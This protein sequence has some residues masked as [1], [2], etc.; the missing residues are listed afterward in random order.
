MYLSHQ[1]TWLHHCAALLYS[2]SECQVLRQGTQ[3]YSPAKMQFPVLCRP[4]SKRNMTA[5]TR[6]CQAQH[7]SQCLPLSIAEISLKTMVNSPLLMMLNFWATRASFTF[8]FW[9]WS[10][11]LHNPEM[12]LQIANTLYHILCNPFV[13]SAF[14]FCNA[15]QPSVIGTNSTAVAQKL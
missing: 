15:T 3:S 6:V 2:V 11:S 12:C 7:V 10:F 1:R 4:M 14:R 13:L 9:C 5:F 8:P